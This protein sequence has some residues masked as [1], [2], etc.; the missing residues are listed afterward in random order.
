MS[1]LP[2][3]AVLG[4]HAFRGNKRLLFRAKAPLRISFGGGGT[5]VPPFP[6]QE[7]G[8]VL[9]AYDRAV[10]IQQPC[11]PGRILQ[12]C[13]ESLD[14]GETVTY[15]LDDKLVYDGKLDLVKAAILHVSRPRPASIFLHSDAPPGS[16]LGASSTVMVTLVGLLKEWKS[17]PLTDYEIADMAYRIERQELG[18]QGGLQDQ[19]SAAFG[20]F[21]YIEFAGDQVIVNPL[22]IP[23]DVQNELQYNLLLIF[24][25]RSR[26]SAR[27]I[28]DQVARFEAGE[29]D[30]IEA[31]RATGS[32]CTGFPLICS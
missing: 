2:V 15:S 24:T 11:S 1:P 28:E 4:R 23:A 32:R 8:V 16:G 27:I 14:F 31:L 17:L 7:G 21:N 12:I 6:Q 26:L 29:S 18:I 3:L 25:G 30:S 19:Y 20:G 13:I 22:R 5:D 9:S 10:C